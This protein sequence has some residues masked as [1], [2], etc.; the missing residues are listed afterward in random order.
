MSLKTLLSGYAAFGAASGVALLLVPSAVMAIY[1]VP[2]LDV[3]ETSL[4]RDVGTLM[5]GLSVMCWVARRAEASTARAALT[6]GLAVINGLW[7]VLAAVAGITI[8]GWFI[9]AEVPFFT[10]LAALFTMA[11]R[12]NVEGRGPIPTGSSDEGGRGQ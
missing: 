9:W 8:G 7:A 12:G 10:V 11:M 5:V 1:G 2:S 6:L 4:A 3:V